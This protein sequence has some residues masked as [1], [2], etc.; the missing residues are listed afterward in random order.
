MRA[1]SASVGRANKTI[2]TPGRPGAA[3][4]RPECDRRGGEPHLLTDSVASN[5]GLRQEGTI[6]LP[7]SRTLRGAEPTVPAALVRR[8]I[9][10]WFAS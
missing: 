6:V 2:S 4:A 5:V 8:G 7:R 9:S 1:Y 10:R 3:T